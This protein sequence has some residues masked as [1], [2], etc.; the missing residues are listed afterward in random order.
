MS[1]EENA[2][3]TSSDADDSSIVVREFKLSTEQCFYAIGKV[4]ESGYFDRLNT[5]FS[6]MINKDWESD[7]AVVHLYVS[8][9]SYKDGEIVFEHLQRWYKAIAEVIELEPLA[10]RKD[11]GWIVNNFKEH[12]DLKAI[13]GEELVFRVI[14]DFPFNITK[15]L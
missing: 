6:F 1:T 7:V 12:I 14:E 3:T 4:T 2:T 11:D 10:K 5:G 15:S 9:S 8:H 13:L